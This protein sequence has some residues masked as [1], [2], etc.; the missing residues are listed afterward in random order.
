LSRGAKLSRSKPKK[1]PPAKRIRTA[2]V[3]TIWEIGRELLIP[4]WGKIPHK[5]Y[6]ATMAMTMTNWCLRE[7]VERVKED[8]NVEEVI[9]F[10]KLIAEVHG[11]STINYEHKDIYEFFIDNI[12]LRKDD[13]YITF[14]KRVGV[15][16][17]SILLKIFVVPTYVSP[18]ELL[19]ELELGELYE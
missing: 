14:L 6:V 10:I 16:C 12:R 17:I 13:T 1:A 2:I 9:N 8:I 5:M 15:I 7:Y 3:Q 11:V 4:T 19:G 18:I